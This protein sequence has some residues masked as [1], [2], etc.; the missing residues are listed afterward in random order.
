[1]RRT[2]YAAIGAILWVGSAVSAQAQMPDYCR[3]DRPSLVVVD[4]QAA[5]WMVINSSFAEKSRGK[6]DRPAKGVLFQ[7]GAFGG[8]GADPN[9]LIVDIW[10]SGDTPIRLAPKNFKWI[11]V[12]SVRSTS[13]PNASRPMTRKDMCLLAPGLCDD[14][15]GAACEALEGVIDPNLGECLRGRTLHRKFRPVGV[16]TF[17]GGEGGW[18]MIATP[19]EHASDEKAHHVRYV[20]TPHDPIRVFKD[21]E[22]TPLGGDRVRCV[23]IREDDPGPIRRHHVEHEDPAWP[24]P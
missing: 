10:H 4:D 11:D 9:R 1:M 12:V 7:L 3:E 8:T 14:P 19:A 21:G 23:A 16:L 18:S 22:S 6:G 15:A 13:N 24:V 17:W 5:S 20:F 2:L